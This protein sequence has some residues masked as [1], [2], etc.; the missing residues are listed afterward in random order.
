MLAKLF[1]SNHFAISL[2]QVIMW[3]TVNLYR[4]A[5]QLYLNTTG[6]RIMSCHSGLQV[7]SVD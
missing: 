2:C 4:A 3:Y 1:C 7:G 6:K 5:C